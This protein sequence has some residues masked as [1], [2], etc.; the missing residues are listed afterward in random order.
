MLVGFRLEALGFSFC[1][2]GRQIQP[3]LLKEVVLKNRGRIQGLMC[4]L[5]QGFRAR[6]FGRVPH[7]S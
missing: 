4:C 2:E 5:F 6:S 1:C 7:D 3:R